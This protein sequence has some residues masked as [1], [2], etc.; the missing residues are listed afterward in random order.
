MGLDCRFEIPTGLRLSSRNTL[1]DPRKCAGSRS[2]SLNES[3]QHIHCPH[4]LFFFVLRP[5]Y[6]SLDDANILLFPPALTLFKS[7]TDV[8]TKYALCS[9]HVSWN[10]LL[11]LSSC[12]A[13]APCP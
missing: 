8:N 12:E 10:N 9:R 11:L 2:G 13:K 4:F 3:H 6:K 7:I 5:S 1:Y